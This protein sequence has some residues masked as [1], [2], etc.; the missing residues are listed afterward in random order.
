MGKKLIG[1]FLII[2]ILLGIVAAI[3]YMEMKSINDG[4]T[5][6]YYDRAVPIGTM[7]QVDADFLYI[8]GNLYKYLSIPDQREKTKAEIDEY[9]SAINT[10]M[11]NFRATNLLDSEKE[12][13]AKFDSNWAT[14][15]KVVKE[16]IALI[17]SGKEDEA[18]KSL[19]GG[20]M[21]TS[22]VATD[23]TI[24]ALKEINVKEAERL[25]EEGDVTFGIATLTLTI[26]GI[27]SF[28]FALAL[29]YVIS[30]SITIPL[31]RGVTMMQEVTRGHLGSRL[32]LTRKDEIGDLTR[33]MD[34]FSDV[35]QNTIVSTLKQVSVGDLSVNIKT[36][37]DRDEIA[38][39][40]IQMVEAIRGL[41]AEAKMLSHAAGEGN[42][43]TRGD[44]NRFQGGYREVIVGMNDTFDGVVTPVN[45][46]MRLAGSYADGDYTDH[47]SDQISMKGD[48]IAFKEALNQIGIQG[49]SAIG[50]VKTE[51]E[52]LSA[53]ME[54][55]NASAE[56]VASTT[57]MLAQSSNEVSI[58]AE[59]SG[60]GIKQALT[61]MEDLS[62]TVSSVAG[63]AEQAS[64]M[65][66]QTVDLSEK[67][68]ILAGKAE[69]G[70]EGIMQSAAETGEIIA[71]I[72]G[73]ME[74]IGKIVGVITGIAEQTGL[75]ALNAAIEAAR[76]GDAGMG[77]AVVADEVKSLALESQK[78]AE[79][80]ATII[81]A[82]QKKSL[83]V[84]ESMNVSAREVKAGNEAVTET[85]GV[86]NEIVQ[87]INIVH[88][89]MT[90]VAGATEE[91]A[92]AVE[93]ITASVNEVGNLVQQTAKEAVGSAAATEEVTAS[94]DQITRAI[95][96]ASASVQR[97]STNM[98][99]FTT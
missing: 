7:G 82:L 89:N 12:E 10:D 69:K 44:A 99:R 24:D 38:P 9:I 46:A 60:I 31:S 49:G 20:A 57:S 87:A 17:D 96:D 59:R 92:A 61:A 11:D 34:H 74:E 23:A 8:R 36:Q 64:F 1:S 90:E 29:G 37:D 55:T 2:A 27:I 25:N 85:L 79:N 83:K 28:V 32:H 73:Q 43:N 62:Q 68:V 81:G 77:F 22:R 93:E 15:Q 4:M 67:G 56:E 78:S 18:A 35:L 14:F 16:T 30:R 52:S 80:I 63:K 91:Q 6:M 65:A 84:S 40:M 95:T 98:G 47:I 88:A 71:D 75:L 42:L 33:S 54:E 66:K 72:T 21:T 39:A 76:A 45:E 50:G 53:G 13:L 51:V 86:F 70:M 26:I 41:I 3:G 97:I 94:I 5:A 19:S 48:F 58:I